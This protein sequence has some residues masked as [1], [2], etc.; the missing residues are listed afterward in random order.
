[1]TGGLGVPLELAD[2]SSDAV[3]LLLD[4]FPVPDC[5]RFSVSASPG[6]PA[7]D[8]PCSSVPA[9]PR[10]PVPA[11]PE[12]SVPACP[13][14]P[15]AGQ[16]GKGR[17]KSESNNR[18]LIGFCCRELSYVVSSDVVVQTLY[19]KGFCD[20]DRIYQANLKKARCHRIRM[21]R[22]TAGER[23]YLSRHAL[24]LCAARLLCAT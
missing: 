19:I 14:F 17:G 23:S 6:F 13:R 1:M 11:S 4:C 3:R 24:F 10:F 20:S 9:C 8:C 16:N 5:S 21:H 2:G 18:F 15:E 12:F 22:S 7:P